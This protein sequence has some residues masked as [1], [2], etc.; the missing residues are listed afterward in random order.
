MIVSAYY[1]AKIAACLIL[2]V[3][4]TPCPEPDA[5][6]RCR[7]GARRGGNTLVEDR[8]GVGCSA[9]PRAW[10]AE[11]S[12]MVCFELRHQAWNPIL[13]LLVWHSF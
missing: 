12:T 13:Q 7:W 10:L 5:P 3:A 8:N 1:K 2:E 11:G 9:E 6:G 4:V